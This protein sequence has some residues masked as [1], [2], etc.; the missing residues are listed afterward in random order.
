ME[1]LN[2]K[3]IFIIDRDSFLKLQTKDTSSSLKVDTFAQP[4]DS[5]SQFM[6]DLKEW[7]GYS[8]EQIAQIKARDGSKEANIKE[9]QKLWDSVQASGS[10]I[11]TKQ[12]VK[13]NMEIKK[14]LVGNAASL[15]RKQQ[16][17]KEDQSRFEDVGE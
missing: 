8:D 17:A 12:D 7:A 1:P 10:N 14:L 11:M 2:H 15:L 4:V 6:L 3:P 5:F 9:V 16:S 13:V